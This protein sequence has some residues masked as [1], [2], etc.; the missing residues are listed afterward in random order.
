MRWRKYRNKLQDCSLRVKLSLTYLVSLFVPLLIITLFCISRMTQL[1]QEKSFSASE[2]QCDQIASNVSAQ[3]QRY[4]DSIY[5]FAANSL[6]CDIFETEYKDLTSFFRVYPT[7]TAYINTFLVSNPNISGLVLYTDNPTF[8]S[9]KDSICPLDDALLEEYSVKSK[10]VPRHGT[11]P[12]TVVSSLRSVG[13]EHCFSLTRPVSVRQNPQYHTLLV[14]E[15]PESEIYSLYQ[16]ESRGITVYLQAPTGEVF[17]SSDRSSIGMPAQQVSQ[18]LQVRS[19]AEEAG[20]LYSRDGR[21]YYRSDFPAD[22]ILHGWE[23]F[24]VVSDETYAA[25]MRTLMQQTLLMVAGITLLG[26]ALILMLSSSMTR[27]LKQLADTVSSIRGNDFR[28][29]IECGAQDEI[30]T[31]ARAFQQMLHRIE[32]LIADV[33][34]SN[35]RVKD[36]EIRNKQAELNALQSQINPHFLFNTMQSISISSYSNHDLETAGYINKFC[37]FLRDSL[38]W[39]KGETTLAEELAIVENYLTLQ[40]LRY[41]DKFSFS[42]QV[43]EAYC[44]MAIPK[45]TIQP[46]VENALEHGIVGNDKAEEGLVALTASEQQGVLTL[47]VHD[48]GIG[49]RPEELQHLKEQLQNREAPESRDASIG[50]LNTNER[51]RLFYGETFGLTVESRPGQGT[52]V[53]IRLPVKGKE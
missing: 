10:Q 49:F 2:M 32:N 4:Y 38:Y 11:A 27:R 7:V 23:L 37:R 9:N 24:F 6:V 22:S 48:N 52:T 3:L 15:Y 16:H 46:I 14:L 26:L 29:P 41:Q 47:E 50:L 44:G 8:I 34:A 45:F 40:K 39:E 1:A 12:A 18:I 33:C 51:L 13:T 19:L 53:K 35:M 43:P 42:I 17:S 21:F 31:L 28:V 30:G 25:G 36:L 5:T 20:T